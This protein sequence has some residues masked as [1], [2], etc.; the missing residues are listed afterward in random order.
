VARIAVEIR[1]P[2]PGCSPGRAQEVAGHAAVRGSRRVGG[3]AAARGERLWTVATI[4]RSRAAKPAAGE[5]RAPIGDLS[6]SCERAGLAYDAPVAFAHFPPVDERG[7]ERLRAATVAW[8]PLLGKL[9]AVGLRPYLELEHGSH[10]DELRLYCEV[11]GDLLLD[12]SICDEGL[13]DT[14]PATLEEDWTA[15]VQS[16]HGAERYLA[17]VIIEPPLTFALLAIKL[18]E[19]IDA[20]SAGERPLRTTW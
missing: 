8:A 7:A 9:H 12:A 4:A 1:R 20:V 2:L 5:R 14:P 6:W 10:D 19:L 18:R 15:F 11:D 16:P 13:P 17:D 3:T